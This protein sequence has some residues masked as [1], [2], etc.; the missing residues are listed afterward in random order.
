MIENGLI[1]VL[2]QHPV[3]GWKFNVHSAEQTESGNFHIL[4]TP[5]AKQEEKKGTPENIVNL[6]KITADISDQCIMKDYSRKKTFVEFKQELTEET[7]NH[8]IRPRIENANRKIVEIVRQGDITIYLREVLSDKFIY[9]RLSIRVIKNP[10]ECL[11]NFVKDEDGFRYFIS[12]TNGGREIS[13][14]TEQAVILSDKPS[15]ILIGSEI[16]CVENIESKKLVPFFTKDYIEVPAKSEETYLKSFVLKTF[17][18]Y[19]VKIQGITVLEVKP[20]KKAVLS[21]EKDL[22]GELTLILLYEYNGQNRFTSG[23]NKNK[24]IRI[25]KTD[26][27]TCICWYK[28]D[29]EWEAGLAKK[30]LNEGLTVKSAGHYYYDRQDNP[31]SLIEW[32]NMKEQLLLQDFALE[33]RMEVEYYTGDVSINT[34]VSDKVDWFDVDIIVTVGE[35]KIPFNHFRKHILKGNKDFV[36]PEGKVLIF[37]DEWFEKYSEL[38]SIC[39]GG[40]TVLQGKK[41]HAPLL[42]YALDG[43]LSA[44]ETKM[45]SEVLDIP[46]ERPT[47]PPEIKVELRP[48]QKE[49]F[50]WLAHLYNNKFGACLADDMGLGKTLQTITLI[51]HIYGQSGT[52]TANSYGQVKKE[53]SANTHGLLP[54]FDNSVFP[55]SLVIAPTSL[56]HNWKNELCRFAPELKTFVYAGNERLNVRDIQKKFSRYNVI[57]CSYGIIRNDI[58]SLCSYPFQMVILD[59]SQYIKNPSSLIYKAVTQ[60]N[61]DF[62]MVLTGTPVENSLEDL[63]AQFNFIN[64]GLLSSFSVF[65]KDFINRILKEK[66]KD[67]EELLKKMINPFMLRRT[68]EEVA[69]ELPS[70]TQEVI[71]CSMTEKHQEAYDAEKNRIRN[72]II[73]AKEHPEIKTNSF[74]ILEGLNK[75]RQIANHPKLIQSDYTDDSGKFEQIIMS[76]E[77]LKASNHKVLIFSSFVKHLNLLAEKF[78]SEGWKYAMLT[79]ETTKREEEI[80]RFTD[81][82]DVSCFLISLKAGSTGLNLTAADYVFI[83]DP[84]WNPASEMQALSRAHRIGQEK[85][86]IA[87]RFISSETV[88][89]KILHLQKNKQKLFENFVN[90]ANPLSQFNWNDI[91]ELL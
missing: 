53:P 66:R 57:I 23:S 79:G 61:S 72:I 83:I 54:L 27:A 30:L 70:L 59:E 78:N 81:N 10:T 64:E 58:E 8:Y 84:W 41:Q 13:L 73:E 22:H 3:F 1:L 45:F 50:Y 80:K 40:G 17:L 43:L 62:K 35:Y 12:L 20:E 5:V 55:A 76:F 74:V 15:T 47:I 16:H 65:R 37:P 75:L 28:R 14:R 88:E 69:P 21:L 67:K 68:K 44:K 63:W 77:N 56:L 71:Y 7:L 52:N 51:Q 34:I 24:H 38:F 90:N 46:V 49:G 85:P 86:V 82:D 26:G 4:G 39:K 31:F 33:Q 11:F 29:E 36:L 42:Q 32:L 91:E 18:Q 2:S 6:I 60:L 48:Y 87:Y 25:E 19:E 89:E 9:E